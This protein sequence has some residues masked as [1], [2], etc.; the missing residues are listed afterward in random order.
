MARLVFLPQKTKSN[1][2]QTKKKVFTEFNELS[3]HT[4]SFFFV[5]L[6]WKFIYEKSFY[7]LVLPD[8]FVC[9]IIV[10]IAVMNSFVLRCRFFYLGTL[11]QWGLMWGRRAQ[12]ELIYVSLCFGK[13]CFLY[14]SLCA[15][16]GGG[17]AATLYDVDVSD[18]SLSV[19]LSFTVVSRHDTP[20]VYV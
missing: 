1:N 2:R 3:V 8:L 11:L 18:V 20:A 19:T 12:G 17:K 6:S 7:R 15:C 16:C 9:I 13:S 4:M 14:L 10:V 5:F